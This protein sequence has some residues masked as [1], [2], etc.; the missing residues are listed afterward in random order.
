MIKPRETFH[1]I[2]PIQ[3]KGEWMIRLTD[4]EVYNSF[5]IIKERNNKFELFKYPDGESVSAS[6][7]KVRDEIEKDLSIIDITASNL[8]DDII[9]RNIIKKCRNQVTKRMKDDKYLRILAIFVNSIFQDFGS[10]LRTEVDLVGDDVRL[11][12]DENNSSFS[13]YKI[14]PGIYTFKDNSQALISFVQLEYPGPNNVIDIEFDDITR[15]TKFVVR[16]VIIA[17]RF[18]EKS[19][20]STI[21]GFKPYWDYKH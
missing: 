20:F 3:I 9:G 1:F 8:E 6:Y 12:L 2:T 7:E 11:V 4:L 18:D 15:E 10:F 13:T 16:D 19:F 14:Q 21:P 5:F 17:I